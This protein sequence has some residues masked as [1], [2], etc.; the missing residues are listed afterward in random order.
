MKLYYSKGACSLSVRIV[1]QEI[2][3][4]YEQESVNLKTKKTESGIDYLTINPKGAVPAL[5]LAN[6]EILTENLAIQQYLAD[7]YKATP[8]LPMI[9]NFKRYRVLEWLSYVSSDLH[10]GFGPLFNPTLPQEV[11]DQIFIPNLQKKYAWVD[12]HLRKNR[13]LMGDQYTLPDCYLFV[14]SRWLKAFNISSNEYP[15][16]LR[17]MEDIKKRKAV[18]DALAEEGLN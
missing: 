2:G 7:E 16:L 6:K 13:F 3:V 18:A 12:E 1:L 17:Y 14:V 8:L 4:P 11:K 5:E 9:G 10:K 15:N